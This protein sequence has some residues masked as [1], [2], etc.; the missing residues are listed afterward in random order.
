[1]VVEVVYPVLENVRF[2]TVNDRLKQTHKFIILC[3]C[4][5]A[6]FAVKTY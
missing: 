4:I 1:M 5:V 6:A 2:L 3:A